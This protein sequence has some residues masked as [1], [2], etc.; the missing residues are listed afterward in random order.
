M[1]KAWLAMALGVAL[2]CSSGGGGGGGDVDPD[3]VFG[4]AQLAA[5][6]GG[7]D[8]DR[9][10]KLVQHPVDEDRW[11]VV[12]QGGEVH[13]F[14][15]SDPVAT[16][17]VAVDVDDFVGDL[18]SANE[19]GLLSMVFDRDFDTTGE[20]YLHYTDDTV[21][22]ESVLVLARYVSPD[23]GL[24]FAP[25]ASPIVLEIDHP[26]EE[27]HNGGDLHFGAADPYLYYSVGDG[28]GANDPEGNAQDTSVLLGSVLRLDVNAT[29]AA[30]ET[31]V[32]PGS[33]PF[34]GNPLCDMGGVSPTMD[35]C[36]EI[37][38]HGLRNPW[39]MA[40]DPLT[41][42]LY[43]GDVGQNAL[44]EIDRIVAGGNYGWD[45]AEGTIVHSSTPPCD[46]GAWEDPLAVHPRS[47]ARS[48]TGGVVYRGTDIPELVGLYVYGDFI[49]GNVWALDPSAGDPLPLDLPQHNIAS[50]GQDAQGEVYLVTFGSPSLYRFVPAPPPPP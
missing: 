5:A 7:L 42:A 18:G 45:C 17:A 16:R 27:N 21:D 40:F 39:R 28:G 34:A 26:D 36:P 24:S 14:L 10:V 44:E 8:F 43:L 9:P 41:G 33:N 32:I 20:V 25:A 48:I 15:A 37:Y 23:G 6:F 35:D 47:E 1:R 50:F 29:P 12:E 38:A 4:A 31:Y 22:G 2:A 49:T 13:T 46:P 11:Y 19:Q 3:E 30:G